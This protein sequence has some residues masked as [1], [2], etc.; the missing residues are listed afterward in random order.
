M[1]NLL[2]NIKA[3][4]FLREN[5]NAD[6]VEILLV[7]GPDIHLPHVDCLMIRELVPGALDHISDVVDYSF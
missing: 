4:E 3:K 2:G 7:A 6:A 1:I 5:F